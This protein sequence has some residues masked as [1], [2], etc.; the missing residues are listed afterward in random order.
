MCYGI[1]DNHRRSA[2]PTF[3]F[4]TATSTCTGQG[5]VRAGS[6]VVA[7]YLTKEGSRG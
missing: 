1:S 5:K 7:G 2:G 6:G 3:I 4:P